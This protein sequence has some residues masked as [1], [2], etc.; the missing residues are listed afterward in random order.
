MKSTEQIEQS[1]RR[2]DL[3]TSD[4]KRART[5][6]DLIEAHARQRQKTPTSGR[7]SFRRTIMTM[8]TRRIAAVLALAV[9]LIV[10]LG[11]G[12]GSVAFSQAGHAV[13]S[14]LAWL[15][16]A[17][18]GPASGEPEVDA[19]A[20]PAVARETS[21]EVGKTIL[22]AARYFNV[23]ESDA[24]IWRSLKGRGIEF[25]RVSADPEVYYTTLSRE[26]IALFDASLTLPCLAAPRVIATEGCTAAIVVRDE[27]TLKDVW[28]LGLGLLGTVSRDGKEVQSTL[29][30]HDG[31]RGFELPNVSTESGGVVLLRAKGMFAGMNQDGRDAEEVL[32]RLQVDVQ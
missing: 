10:A 1:I 4:E 12:T 11:L 18:V 32:I 22:Y 8:G 28:G 15:R 9:V 2:L 14:T 30:F 3:Q 26:Q 25:V 24:E 27:H 5:R 17:I 13:N 16:Q 20:L 29:S 23:A 6:R 7:R 19:P 21:E 31:H